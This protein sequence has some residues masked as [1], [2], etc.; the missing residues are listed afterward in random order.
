[1]HLGRCPVIR[2]DFWTYFVDLIGEMGLEKPQDLDKFL[3]TG[4]MDEERVA[5]EEVIG[6]FTIAWR[7]LYAEIAKGR[8]ESVRVVL[9]CARRRAMAM[10]HSRL[11]AYGRSTRDF[12]VQRKNSG[13]KFMLPKKLNERTTIRVS[14]D[15][16]YV[17]HRAITGRLPGRAV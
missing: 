2:R 9:D 13:R 12:H 8:L 14:R 4:A 17:I 6:I 5:C 15:G 3:M 1:M 11:T 10:I 7:C 16:T